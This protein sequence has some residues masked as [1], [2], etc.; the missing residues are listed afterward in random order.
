MFFKITR[1]VVAKKDHHI[2]EPQNGSVKPGF[3]SVV[4]KTTSVLAKKSPPLFWYK[5]LLQYRGNGQSYLSDETKHYAT[6]GV[7]F[8]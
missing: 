2:T 7:Y 1:D 6:C 3:D 5:I 4:K 8:C